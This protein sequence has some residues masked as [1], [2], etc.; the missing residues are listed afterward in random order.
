[1]SRLGTILFWGLLA[2]A[3]CLSLPAETSHS[4]SAAPAPPPLE[5]FILP[6]ASLNSMSIWVPADRVGPLVNRSCMGQANR[7]YSCFL[8]AD[9]HHTRTEACPAGLAR[10]LAERAACCH[11]QSVPLTIFNGWQWE[12][13]E[14]PCQYESALYDLE[15]RGG[16]WEHALEAVLTRTLGHS[17]GVWLQLPGDPNSP[18]PVRTDSW[19]SRIEASTFSPMRARDGY[20]KKRQL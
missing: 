20:P 8:P 11:E 3:L 2:P 4:S 12:C 6:P 15:P 10:L 14:T 1:M 9:V 5:T 17:I 19:H 13:S 16:S 7:L 18:V